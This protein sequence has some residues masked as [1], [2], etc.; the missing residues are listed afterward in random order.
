MK[1]TISAVLALAMLAVMCYSGAKLRALDAE[2]RAEE[3]LHAELLRQKPEEASVNPLAGLREQNPDIIGWINLP[4]TGIDYPIA[5]A[6]DN[7]YYLRRDLNGEP[8]RPGTIFM[9][10]R[11]AGDGSGYSIIYGHN[12]KSGSMFGPLQKF[13]DKDFFET[14]PEGRLLLEDG[15]HTLRFFAFLVVRENDAVLYNA[16]PDDGF[17]ENIAARALNYREPGIN[18]TDRVVTL[19]TCSYAFRGARMALVGVIVD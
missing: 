7:D 13:K 14:H 12:M 9:D 3:H 19:S 10:C 17:L 5:Q 15:W 1:K 2:R 16:S 8:A 6:K 11:C 18:D 4:D